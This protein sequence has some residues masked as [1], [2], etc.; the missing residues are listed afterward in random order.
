M[1]KS[2]G[3]VILGTIVVLG[4]LYLY[5]IG[6][7]ETE[8][9]NSNLAA[10]H[11]AVYITIL[12]VV[13]GMSM[14]IAGL[15]SHLRS[16]SMPNERIGVGI[17]SRTLNDK[18]SSR[19]LFITSL[20]YAVLFSILSGTLILRSGG[21]FSQTYGVSVPSIVAVVCCGSIGQMP[22]LVAY[23]TQQVALVIVPVNVVLLFVVSWLV[24]MNASLAFYAY[25]NRPKSNAK[26]LTGLGA[27]IG[28]FTAC[29]TCSGLFFLTSIGL[30]ATLS[31]TL[32]TGLYQVLFVM[33]SVPLLIATL[34]LTSNRVDSELCSTNAATKRHEP[35]P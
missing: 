26:W 31:A 23:A 5:S 33:T 6:I 17:L 28:L 7:S 12:A 15:T 16:L 3:S 32:A 22:Q 35:N 14:V 20:M 11:A 19:I 9:T 2:Q 4:S 13:A 30:S 18:P 27:T 29:P 1:I 8:V 24:G 34:L 25:R 10:L 21:A